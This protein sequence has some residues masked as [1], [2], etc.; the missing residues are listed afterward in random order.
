MFEVNTQ[1]KTSP[2]TADVV[3]YV[4]LVAPL[5]LVPFFFH[6]YIGDVPPLVGVAV[7]AKLPPLQIGFEA[8]TIAMLGVTLLFTVIVTALLV[9]VVGDAHEALLV[10]TTVTTSL[11]AKV[12]VAKVL[13]LVPAF[14]PFTFH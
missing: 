3:L 7:N 11:F 12:L 8:A 6:W 13:L 10:I 1:V 5:I 2:F 14:T 4:K 9:A